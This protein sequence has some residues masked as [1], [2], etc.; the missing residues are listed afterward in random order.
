MGKTLDSSQGTIIPG[1]PTSSLLIFGLLEP[2]HNPWRPCQTL[3]TSSLTSK[4]SLRSPRIF[5]RTL[6]MS[7]MIRKLL[8]I[9]I[10]R[11][12]QEP[13]EPVGW[14]LECNQWDLKILKILLEPYWWHKEH[15]HGLKLYKGPWTLIKDAWHLTNNQENPIKDTWSGSGNIR[16][17]LVE[18]H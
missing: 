9:M 17:S 7:W 14:S 15:F 5:L 8:M 10:P 4:S 12:L 13:I 1:F 11:P 18:P 2:C 3:L 16:I 6:R